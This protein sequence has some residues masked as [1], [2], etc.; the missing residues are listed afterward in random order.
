MSNHGTLRHVAAASLLALVLV[1]GSPAHAAGADDCA[2]DRGPF[3]WFTDLFRRAPACEGIDT[4]RPLPEEV[5]TLVVG[6]GPGGGT[7]AGKLAEGGQTVALLDAGTMNVLPVSEALSAFAASAEYRKK[8][9]A[10][11]VERIPESGFVANYPRLAGLG[12][13]AAGAAGIITPF[14]WSAVDAMARRMGDP[15]LGS[16]TLAHYQ[17]SVENARWDLAGRVEEFFLGRSRH[18]HRGFQK[19]GVPSLATLLSTLP[20][21][22]QLAPFYKALLKSQDNS[23]EAIFRRG[24]G[25]G[26]LHDPEVQKREGIVV[27]PAATDEDGKR[28]TVAQYIAQTQCRHPDRL[29]LKGGAVVDKILFERNAD[30]SLRA[31]GVEYLEGAK[32]RAS[33]APVDPGAPAPVRRVVRARNVVVANS[34]FGAVGTLQRSGIGPR[35]ELDRLGVETLLDRPGV[36]QRVG[37]RLEST[38]V[39]EFPEEFKVLGDLEAAEKELIALSDRLDANPNDTEAKEAVKRLFERQKGLLTTNGIPLAMMWKSDP[40]LAEPD[41]L[42]FGF[43]GNFTN[44]RKGFSHDLTATK[45][46]FSVIMLK[47]DTA[48]D[49]TAVVNSTDPTESPKVSVAYDPKGPDMRAMAKGLVRFNQEIASKLPGVK[50]VRGNVT[51][52]EEALEFLSNSDN[53]FGHHIRGGAPMGPASDPLAVVDS[54]QK[55]YGTSNVYVAGT[56]AWNGSIGPFPI[57]PIEAMSA[58]LAD[59]M[60]A[61]GRGGAPQGAR[62]A[63]RPAPR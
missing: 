11:G 58:R 59:K 14:T 52:E 33:G 40:S 54:N 19:T 30:G 46:R 50:V 9:L 6:A 61:G 29:F 47:I 45:N 3:S 35:A 7:V 37:D 62:S 32:L 36:G 34:P 49:G 28:S 20:D 26:D 41:L 42:F 21:A 16:K 22:P 10:Y 24:L 4:T 15:T 57:L 48:S 63:H 23:V 5:D 18:G 39:M 60:L 2:P 51:T 55:V 31:V 1:G 38:V 12:G 44:F 43:P 25:G 27:L 13:S 56:A 17:R 53:L 8:A